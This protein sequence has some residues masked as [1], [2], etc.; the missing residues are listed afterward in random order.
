MFRRKSF[1]KDCIFEA[2]ADNQFS[3]WQWN[4]CSKHFM[5]IINLIIGTAH[6]IYRQ[7]N[8]CKACSYWKKTEV[9]ALMLS[10]R[11]AC[12]LHSVHSWTKNPIKALEVT[13]NIKRYKVTRTK[14]F[15]LRL[16]W[17]QLLV[18]G[19]AGEKKNPLH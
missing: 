10:R 19:N 16:K 18:M 3:L 12:L 15:L 6:H 7:R 17:F 1:S 4:M 8:Y 2:V 9:F 5:S 11:R 13:N 14:W